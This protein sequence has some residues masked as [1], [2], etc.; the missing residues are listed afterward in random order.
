[1]GHS[2][3]VFIVTEGKRTDRWFYDKLARE[4]SALA[5]KG[6]LVYTVASITRDVKGGGEG[7]DAV[8]RLFKKLRSSG[9]L[10]QENSSGVKSMIFCVDADHDRFTR[11]MLRSDHL[12]YTQLPDAE[13]H[14]LNSCDLTSVVGYAASLPLVEANQVV[15]AL[16]DWQSQF[17]RGRLDW[18]ALCCAAAMTGIE[19][20]PRPGTPPTKCHS[21]PYFPAREDAV[22]ALRASLEAACGT[23]K[24]EAFH[25]NERLAL[26][27]FRT[28][29]ESGRA[30]RT[31]KGKWCLRFLK[32]A[33]EDEAG[34][35]SG[36]TV[37]TAED[38]ILSSAKAT[39]N[40]VSQWCVEARAR[41]MR[42]LQPVE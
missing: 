13:A 42:T 4:D 37:T 9:Q 41:I 39:A 5:D 20:S 2:E 29:I 10:R 34:S 7:K 40:F 33:I 18:M 28:A 30:E 8:L 26:T 24:I 25:A 32:V 15:K 12:I 1:M 23:D 38:S 22:N 27:R 36:E 6:I 21:G 11:K 17:A 16:G 19:N 35:V 31:L 14:I 3:S